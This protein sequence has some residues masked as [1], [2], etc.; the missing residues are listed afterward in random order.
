MAYLGLVELLIKAFTLLNVGRF[1]T[2]T[3]LVGYS[4]LRDFYRLFRI[5]CIGFSNFGITF[6]HFL[7]YFSIII[8][9]LYKG[10]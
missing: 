5:A 6:G 2:L 4:F 8:R 10:E 7:S 3:L 1:C 9:M